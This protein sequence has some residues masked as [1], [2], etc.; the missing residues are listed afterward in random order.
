[1]RELFRLN[2]HLI[3]G[4]QKYDLWVVMKKRFTKEDSPQI[5]KLFADSLKRVASK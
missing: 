1:M 4:P 2:Q 5:E 3:A